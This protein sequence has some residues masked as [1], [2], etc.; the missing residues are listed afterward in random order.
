MLGKTPQLANRKAHILPVCMREKESESGDETALYR[1]CTVTYRM[2]RN[3]CPIRV[4]GIRAP[5]LEKAPCRSS[6][7]DGSQSNVLPFIT[8]RAVSNDYVFYRFPAKSEGRI[9]AHLSA[10]LAA[11]VDH[12]SPTRSI[13]HQ[14]API[15]FFSR[16]DSGS[17][18]QN[19]CIFRF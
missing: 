1:Y 3:L 16:L 15:F 5:E 12:T 9:K 18:A 13:R 4:S 14:H 7:L 17:R 8:A 2:M 19:S 6:L 10:L 11:L